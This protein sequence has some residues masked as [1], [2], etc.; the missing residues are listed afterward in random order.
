LYGV[1]HRVALRARVTTARRRACEQLGVEAVA[2]APVGD[3]DR[4]DLRPI[5]HEELNR[6]PEKYRAPLVLCYLEGQTNEEAAAQLGW[7]KGTVSGRLA[8]AR[9][10]LRGRLVRR[11]VDVSAGLLTVLLSQ[12]VAD[13]AVP[14]SLFQTTLWSAS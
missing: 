4:H 14:G 11:G 9:D 6:L 3:M 10:L 5:L 12:R 13:A 2:A 8:R 7:T 1:A